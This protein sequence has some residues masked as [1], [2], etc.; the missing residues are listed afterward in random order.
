MA[1]GSPVDTGDGTLRVETGHPETSPKKEIYPV[2][3]GNRHEQVIVDEVPGD[4]R[5]WIN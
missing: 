4:L 3:R 1:A 5:R 2:K